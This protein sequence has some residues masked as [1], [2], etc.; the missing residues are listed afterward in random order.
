MENV[1]FTDLECIL[2]ETIQKTIRE[3]L[4]YSRKVNI[5]WTKKKIKKK[6][7]PYENNTI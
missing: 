7:Y 6:F 2:N 3:S 4:I 5:T 1:P